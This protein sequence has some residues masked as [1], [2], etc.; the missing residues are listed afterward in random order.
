MTEMV[1]NDDPVVAR[2]PWAAYVGERM[3][4]RLSWLMFVA[5]G[6]MGCGALAD[7]G[8]ESGSQTIPVAEQGSQQKSLSDNDLYETGKGLFDQYAPPE[9]KQQFEFPSRQQAEEFLARV[10]SAYEGGSL[11]ELAAYEPQARAL[12][13]A[14]R[15]VPG[16]EDYADWLAARLEE[17]DEA[18][19]ITEAARQLRAPARPPAEKAAPSPIPYYERW[20]RR[21]RGR[22][23]PEN[24]AKWM[25]RLSRAFSEEGAPPELAWLAEVESSFNPSARS[26]SGARGLFQL[27]PG[28]ARGLGLS[29]FLPDERAD[30]EKSARAA[31]RRLRS[32]RERF[33]SWPLAL[34]AYNA[35]EGRVQRALASRG[36]S[37]FAGAAD[38]LPAGTRM[39]VPEVCALVAVRT[40][41]TLR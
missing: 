15:G 21:E 3:Q 13:A 33:G 32:L 28:T 22:P 36:A 38:A 1:V 14:L 39:Y 8:P 16:C 34:A 18:R 29:T 40:G 24:A 10:Q 6:F 11:E 5:S 2:G 25:P 17:I 35:G 30:P 20:L 41:K 26:P 19:Q 9:I 4:A 27:M 31:A 12:T 7:G 37:D 23:V